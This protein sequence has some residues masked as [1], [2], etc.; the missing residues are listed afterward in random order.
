MVVLLLRRLGNLVAEGRGGRKVAET[1]HLVKRV[2]DRLG[3]LREPRLRREG[4]AGREGGEH[5]L[6]L[7]PLEA[8]DTL[9][10]DGLLGARGA[11]AARELRVHGRRGRHGAANR[12]SS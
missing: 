3:A 11:R 4:P 1:V 8:L 9:L 7:A 5:R 2:W 10:T 12:H 6:G